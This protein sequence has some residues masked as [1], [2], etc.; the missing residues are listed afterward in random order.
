[1]SYKNLEVWKLA[2]RIVVEIHKMTLEDLPKFEMYETGQQIRKSSKSIK[3]N[4]VEGYGRKKYQQ[5]YLHFLII[6]FGSLLETNDHLDTLFSVQSLKNEIK[7][8][9]LHSDLELLGKQLNRL[10]TRISASLAEGRKK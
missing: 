3:S 5:D 7:Y 4:I 9:S 8:N 1:M 2:D 6:S 10:I